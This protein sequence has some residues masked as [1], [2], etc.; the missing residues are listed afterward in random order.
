MNAL[1]TVSQCPACGTA[2]LPELPDCAACG[3]VQAVRL[4]RLLTDL[5]R[6]TRLAS[7]A[8]AGVDAYLAEV[9]PHRPSPPPFVAPK[10]K[11]QAV[12][13]QSTPLLQGPPV[14]APPASKAPNPE[15]QAV[16]RRITPQAALLA[17]GVLLVMGAA[18]TFLAVVWTRLGLTVQATIMAAI[19][20]AFAGLSVLASRRRLAASAEAFALLG[21]GVLAADLIAARARHLL[22][23]GDTPTYAG[24]SCAVLA[25][26]C[27]LIHRVTAT[28]VTFGVAAVLLAQIPVPALL[29]SAD[30]AI[31]LVAVG[32][33]ALLTARWTRL[34]PRA[35]RVTGV[36]CALTGFIVAIVVAVGRALLGLAG[37]IEQPSASASAAAAVV[38]AGTGVIALRRRWFGVPLP[39]P[40]SEVA[41]TG[42]A[43]LAVGATA[44]QVPVAGAWTVI[45]LATLLAVAE[46]VRPAYRRDWVLRPMMLTAV[47]VLGG[48]AV[49]VSDLGQM[50]TLALIIGALALLA[51]HRRRIGAAAATSTACAAPVVAVVLLA[52]GGLVSPWTAGLVSALVAA[53]T[54]AIA[55][56]RFGGPGERAALVVGTGAT[57]VGVLAMR[58]DDNQTGVALVLVLAAAP[59]LAY[60]RLPG[61]RPARLLA[62]VLLTAANTLFASAKDVGIL[63]L[64]TVPPALLMLGVGLMRP[65]HPSSWVSLGPG[66]L[67]GLVPS[68]VLVIAAPGNPIRLVFV[69]ATALALVVVGT[70]FSL[71][72][73]FVIGAGVLAK[74]GIW[75]LVLIT[76]QVP[77][78]VTLGVAGA[79]LLAVGATYER[80]I[81]DAQRTAR[82]IAQLR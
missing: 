6:A 8:K 64:Y 15:R 47:A 69:V 38:L 36:A 23:T 14:P 53:G 72:A 1:A 46:L 68:S 49:I 42:A 34:A 10:P 12:R 32:A 41:C 19:G 7:D 30:P 57:V 50:A 55:T 4:A 26:L 73:P 58:A 13:R 3:Q 63:E 75:Q 28:I 80:R 16:P 24:L 78:W 33:Q 20:L 56:L 44:A 43:A 74:L 5:E 62:V 2:L 51:R 66:L 35:M 11:P 18:V 59:L 22:P 67:L 54:V 39:R 65:R 70:Q 9:R 25:L 45:V 52:L 21:L 31:L 29:V 77:R 76:P 61:R 27:L 79:T 37:Y 71:Q 40:G 81:A 60:C 48:M 17:L 82:W